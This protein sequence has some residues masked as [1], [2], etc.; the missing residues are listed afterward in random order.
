MALDL[1]ELELEPGEL[2]TVEINAC[3]GKLQSLNLRNNKLDESA[4]S[5]LALG[6][7]KRLNLSMNRLRTL[8]A[9]IATSL[10]SL[11]QLDLR[12]NLELRELPVELAGLSSLQ[13]LELGDLV[14]TMS[15][16]P[17]PG[18]QPAWA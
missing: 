8:P 11:E 5:G 2:P 12:D 9:V 3:A 10:P 17:S 13:E 15:S 14:R 18:R 7:L 4:V 1:S 16:P 6:G